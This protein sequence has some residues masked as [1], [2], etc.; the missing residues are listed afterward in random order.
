MILQFLCQTLILNLLLC[1]FIKYL[2]LNEYDEKSKMPLQRYW[3]VE[4]ILHPVL[5]TFSRK[6]L[7]W[8]HERAP[9]LG[10]HHFAAAMTHD[11]CICVQA[12]RYIPILKLSP[13]N[14]GTQRKKVVWKCV[15]RKR[16]AFSDDLLK[17]NCYKTVARTL[18]ARIQLPFRHDSRQLHSWA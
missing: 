15:H 4:L 9:N 10:G 6:E 13:A 12:S 18:P 5:I 2:Y 3:F 7:N 8:W 17:T 14:M 11:N 16:D 1:R